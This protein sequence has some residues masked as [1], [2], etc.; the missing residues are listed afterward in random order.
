MSTNMARTF[1]KRASKNAYTSPSQIRLM[2]FE[3]PFEKILNPDNR[4]VRL[5]H[6]IPWDSLVNVY[7]N[8]LNNHTTGASN[9]NPRV[10]LGSLM[11][12]H[13]MNLSDEETIQMIQENLYIQYFLGFEG[14]TNEAPFDASLFVEIR[15]RLGLEQL[16]RINDAIYHASMK[17]GKEHHNTAV[18]SSDDDADP[19][20][21]NAIGG[22]G[23]DEGMADTA[24]ASLPNHGRMLVDATACPQDIAYPTDLGLLNA[25]REKCEQIIDKLYHTE[26]HGPVKPRTHRE[27]ARRDYLNTA[28]KKKRTRKELRVAIGKQLRYVRRDLKL[29]GKLLATFGEDPLKEKDRRYLETIGMVYNQQLKMWKGKTHSVEDRIVSIHQ[30]HVRPIV[31]GK[32]KAKVEFGSKINVSLV[33]GFAFLD[34]LCW[35]AYNE[36]GYLMKSVALYKERHGYYPAEVLADQIYCN[37]ENRWL[38]KGMNIRLLAKPLGRPSLQNRIVLNPGDRNPIEGKFGQ[39]KVRYGMDRIRARLKDTS[40]SWVAMIMVVMNLVRLA[41]KAPYFWLR[42]ELRRW[43]DILRKLILEIQLNQT[44]ASIFCRYRLRLIQ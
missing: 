33:D 19:G 4:W 20:A 42:S 26:L 15:K 22:E 25:S 36:G 10:V 31:R 38:L 34:H 23:S 44:V 29:I 43:T 11:V 12:K 2:P 35:D 24:I 3:T 40:E 32:E 41:R 1:K 16:N 18:K 39:A 6:D 9:V 5:A 17:Y 21:G 28:K 14:F 37:R 7:L 8:Q 30:P 27:K 13:M